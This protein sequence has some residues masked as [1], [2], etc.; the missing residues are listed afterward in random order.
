MQQ[1]KIKRNIQK[2]DCILQSSCEM[3]LNIQNKNGSNY[4][5]HRIYIESYT[6]GSRE[7]NCQPFS[8]NVNKCSYKDGFT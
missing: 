4:Y 8:Q 2:R 5:M 7:R 1:Q 6:A 3:E